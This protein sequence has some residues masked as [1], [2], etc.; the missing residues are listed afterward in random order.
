[1]GPGLKEP[2]RLLLMTGEGEEKPYHPSEKKMWSKG[3][4]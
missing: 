1:M 2:W 4:E 3:T